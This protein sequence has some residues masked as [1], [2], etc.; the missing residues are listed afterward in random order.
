M[1][2]KNIL[3]SS[4]PSL[5]LTDDV[6]HALD[7]M[8][9]NHCSELAVVNGDLFEGLVLESDLLSVDE[10]EEI[11]VIQSRFSKLAA[12]A[13]SHVFE[14]VQLANEY[15]LTVVP[16]V[17]KEGHYLG[18]ISNADLL[19]QLGTINGVKTAGAIIVLEMENK[20][21]SFSEISKLVETNDAQITQLNT[22]WDPA[23]ESFLVTLKINKFEVSDILATFQRY[24]YSV[25]HFFGEEQYEN[26]LKSNFDHLMNYLNI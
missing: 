6:R 11:Q 24:E 8:E 25:R 22:H 20:A 10:G 3:S 9:E 7:M 16:V 4:I 12:Q 5:R 26:E 15:H 23:T 14:A 19:L 13:N 18:V 1:L 2:N 17:D 21:F